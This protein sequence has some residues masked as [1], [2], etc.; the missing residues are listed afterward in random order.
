MSKKKTFAGALILVVSLFFL[1]IPNTIAQ[2]C[3][4]NFDCDQDVDGT[5]AARFKADFGRSEHHP[6]PC[7]PCEAGICCVYE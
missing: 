7:P 5:D 6:N 2:L 4:G 1:S 3:E